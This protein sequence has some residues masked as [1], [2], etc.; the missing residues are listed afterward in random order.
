MHGYFIQQDKDIYGRVGVLLMA[1][2][3][4]SKY[5]DVP[6][7]NITNGVIILDNN[8]KV[9]GVKIVPRNLFILE[10]SMQD[11]II[12]NLKNVYNTIDYEF[13]IVV[14]DRP[15]DINVYL[16]QL[17][18]LYNQ[19][20]DARR[21]KLILEDINKANMFKTN[22]VVDTEYFILFKDKS[23]EIL[24]K[25]IRNLINNLAS[26]GLTAFQTNNDDLRMILDNFLNG[27][28]TT[29]FGTVFA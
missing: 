18:L 22:N 27:G 15:V 4:K 8:Q 17:Q 26:A 25:R 12:M 1:N 13:W 11:A 10:Q 2:E 5:T 24:Q 19:S 9:T 6:V 3:K 20:A 23:D 29:E 21:R 16:S 7:K 14:A 28:Q